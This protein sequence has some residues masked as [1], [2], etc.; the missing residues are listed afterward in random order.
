MQDFFYGPAGVMAFSNTAGGS[1]T[2]QIPIQDAVGSTLGLVDSSGA[3]V[4]QYTYDSFGHATA[5]GQ[6]S[7]YPFLF[8]GMESDSSGLYHTLSRY[9]SPTLQRFLS[10]DPL[11]FGGGSTNLFTY[12]LNNPVSNVDPLGQE[13]CSGGDCA[14]GFGGGG[15]A[16]EPTV[17]VPPGLVDQIFNPASWFE[18]LFNLFGLFGG[19]GHHHHVVIP[20]KERH[21]PHILFAQYTGLPNDLTVSNSKNNDQYT[22]GLNTGR[23][24]PEYRN[25]K[26]AGSPSSSCNFANLLIG[27]GACAAVGIPCVGGLFAEPEDAPATL[28]VAKACKLAVPFCLDAAAS[29]A[30]CSSHAPSACGNPDFDNSNLYK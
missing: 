20:R 8:A 2:T 24:S 22:K 6:A 30:C 11:G 16:P 14:G 13:A 25:A 7:N 19:G 28:G 3:M 4:T 26:P 29:I 23:P 27:T 17:Y 1:T 5:S 9:Y 10:E 12:G 15:Q 21:R 18:D